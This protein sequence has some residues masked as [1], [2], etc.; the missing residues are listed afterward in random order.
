MI[1][2]FERCFPLLIQY[3]SAFYWAICVILLFLSVPKTGEYLPYR[4]AKACLATTY[5]LMGL[6][7]MVWLLLTRLGLDQWKALDPRVKCSDFIFFYLETIFMCYSFCYLVDQGYLTRTRKVKDVALLLVASVWIILSLH[8]EPAGWGNIITT[9]FAFLTFFCHIGVFLVR[10]LRLYAHRKEELDDYFP[11][12]MQRFM[13]WIK[14]SLVLLFGMFVLACLTLVFGLAF[15]IVCQV[16]IISVNFYVACSF[17]NYASHYGEL[18]HAQVTEEEREETVKK[19]AS[20]MVDNYEQLF[21]EKLNRWILEKRYLASQLTIDDLASEMGTN[22]LYMS[23]YINRKFEVNFSMLM[24]RLRLAE[25]KEYM[26][27]HPTARQ[28]EVALHSGFSSS[29]YFSKVFS[30]A[31]G[32]TP[33]AWRKENAEDIEK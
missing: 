8:C 27:S 9:A 6:N 19:E 7:L 25:A 18:T 24:T 30:K 2:T 3:A 10:F 14:T 33:A 4:K 16:Y 20:S 31:E 5:F 23:R 15:N 12:D 11:E 13:S 1:Y 32:M 26:L 28:G 22:K 21:G 29:S 17:I